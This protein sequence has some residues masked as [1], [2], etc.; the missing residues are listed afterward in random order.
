MDSQHRRLTTSE[1]RRSRLRRIRTIRR[2]DQAA[3][4]RQ[5][6]QSKYLVD[7]N[8]KPLGV[9][10]FGA[11][12]LARRRDTGEAVA[13][14][15][16]PKGMTDDDTFRNEIN[17]LLR[18]R[19]T[20]GHPHI[21]ALRE[22]FDE[23]KDYCLILE[24]V[25]G[26]EMFD[27]LI[28]N[29]AYSEAD[30][31]RLVREVASALAYLHG[32][33]IVHA[34]LKPEN[35]M[36]STQKSSDSVVKVVDFGCAVIQDEVNDDDDDD[37]VDGSNE[38]D[39][40]GLSTSSEAATANPKP[41]TSTGLTP[42]YS[43][44]E[45]FEDDA[46]IEPAVDMWSLG[47]ILYIMLIGRHPFDHSGKASDEEI[48]KLV[49]DSSVTPPIRNSEYTKYL[50]ESALDLLERLMDR[51]PQK[52]LTAAEMLQHPW[53]TGET[54]TTAVIAGSDERL[55]R[56]RKYK[57][58]LQKRFFED[59]VKWSDDVEDESRR[60]T[61]L[62]EQSFR[63]LDERNEGVVD[64]GE[65]FDDD[66]DTNTD[67]S[68]GRSVSMTD[69]Q[70]LLAENM[71][72]KYFPKGHIVYKQGE[73]GNHMYFINT[74]TILVTTKDGSRAIRKQ[75]DFFG[76]GALL[77]PRKT[78][79]ATVKCKTAVHALEISREYFE[80]FLANSELHM[81][82]REKDKIRK[83]NRAKAI[84]RLQKDL[85]GVELKEGDHLFDAGDEGDSLFVV[86]SGKVD[87]IVN[88]KRVLSVLPGN[89]CGEYSVINGRNR[90]CTAICASEEG[91]KAQP[92]SGNTLRRLMKGSPDMETS[93]KD[94]SLR[95]DFKKAVVYR[96]EKEFPY[97]NPRE[98]FDAV[99][100][101]EGDA[102]SISLEAVTKL[103]REVD[104][105]YPDEDIIALVKV[106]DL[107]GSGTVT[108]DEFK[109]V[110]IADIRTASSI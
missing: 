2:M 27:H 83:R 99:R 92:I 103:M 94:L 109:K 14:K 8:A 38:N 59:A 37:E 96:L 53:V 24:L 91:C 33:G 86:E 48:E 42:A 84:L 69:F 81:T 16:I 50:S 40:F 66:Y 29:G 110:F 85:D 102:E 41:R 22:S 63:S 101:L 97:D 107:T 32:I 65:N 1:A 88:D 104:A 89:V 74:G 39:W 10:A 100:G 56:F 26:G 4:K 3:N 6:L 57:S 64:L 36:L 12:H 19:S 45:A 51:D 25:S 98:A 95:R 61:T 93:L 108:F 49:R 5:S 18:I 17:A 20:G 80:K 78:R 34:D 90:N 82:L 28:K 30:A 70:S 35:L 60:R 54:A 106:L 105:D 72:N 76:E 87:I 79:S 9:G 15:R 7:F 21:C 55:G 62:I 47:V 46:H 67:E 68:G 71:K 43:P 77:H 23:G 58:K 11:V 52:R 31:A 44:P 75:G 13:L 73:I